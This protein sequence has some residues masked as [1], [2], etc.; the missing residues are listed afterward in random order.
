MSIRCLF[1]FF[2]RD[3]DVNPEPPL[4]IFSAF[5]PSVCRPGPCVCGRRSSC[6]GVQL[7]QLA[8]AGFLVVVQGVAVL[9]QGDGGVGVAQQPGEG[10]HVHPL[11][12]GPC[13]EGVSKLVEAENEAILVEV[14][15]GT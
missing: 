2:I 1:L 11:L 6:P 3:A 12:Q 8:D 14:E 13:G 4:L 5:P 9:V 15:N 7:P 10:H